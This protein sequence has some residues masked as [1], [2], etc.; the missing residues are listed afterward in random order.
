MKKYCI[1]GQAT[2]DNIIRL[3]RMTPKSA[4]THTD[5]VIL[6]RDNSVDIATR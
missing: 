5:Y 3:I 6:G 1:A 2:V 4:N